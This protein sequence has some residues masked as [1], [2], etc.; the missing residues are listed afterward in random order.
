MEEK[1][2]KAGKTIGGFI[3]TLLLP[4]ILSVVA[5]IC[6]KILLTRMSD[7]IKE[8]VEVIKVKKN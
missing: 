4:A 8:Y 6:S 3:K 1:F 7:V 5:T 2:F